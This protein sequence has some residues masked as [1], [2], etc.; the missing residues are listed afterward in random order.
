MTLQH[1]AEVEP[2]QTAE[3]L[4]EETLGLDVHTFD[5][6]GRMRLQI[7][8]YSVCVNTCSLNVLDPCGIG[9][10]KI[11]VLRVAVEIEVQLRE[12]EHLGLEQCLKTFLVDVV[13]F[14]IQD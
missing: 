4:S 13:A 7:A 14:K 2:R 12:T 5:V 8:E 1:S 6:S 3:I 9:Q 11:D 10:Q